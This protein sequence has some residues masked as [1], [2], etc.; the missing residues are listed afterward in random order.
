MRAYCRTLQ[1]EVTAIRGVIKMGKVYSDFDAENVRG[2][3][4]T[5]FI[6]AV[7]GCRCPSWPVHA[8]ALL[9]TTGSAIIRAE[10]IFPI[11]IR[12]AVGC[13]SFFHSAVL[14]WAP[15][16]HGSDGHEV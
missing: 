8:F 6:I 15:F 13:A 2:K 14:R 16:G 11:E 1:T 7:F 5:G 9:V 10:N 4:R 3:F 12:P